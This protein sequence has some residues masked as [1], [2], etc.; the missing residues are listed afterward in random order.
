MNPVI[1]FLTGWVVA[2]ADGLERRDR[3]IVTLAAVLPDADGLGILANLASGNQET[4][5]RL[6]GQYHH[7]LAHNIFSGLLIALAAYALAGKKRLSALLAFLC[8]HLHLAE[9]LLSGRGPDGALWPIAYFYPASS[10]FMISWS[11][12]WE[13]NAWPNVVIAAFLLLITFYLAWR[14]GFSPVGIFSPRADSLFVETLR[15]RFGHPAPDG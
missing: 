8:F 13:L 1:H 5:L 12:Q 10:G 3:N 9:D 7:V 4:G 11:G 14:K 15:A 6:Y 2:N